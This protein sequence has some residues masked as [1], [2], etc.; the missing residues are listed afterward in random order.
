MKNKV[1][2]YRAELKKCEAKLAVLKTRCKELEQKIMEAET[3]E[4]HALMR[5]AGLTVED[6]IA[7]TTTMRDGGALLDF[8]NAGNSLG[9]EDQMTAP[10]GD[11]NPEDE[12]MDQEDDEGYE[13]DE[14]DDE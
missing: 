8:L 10:D 9:D 4:I 13:D 2:K 5:S 14:Y 1:E 6:L 7:L 12:Y 3:L 11:T